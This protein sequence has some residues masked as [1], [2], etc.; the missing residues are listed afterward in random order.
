M[1]NV[2]HTQMVIFFLREGFGLILVVFSFRGLAPCVNRSCICLGPNKRVKVT[3]IR[4]QDKIV[5]KVG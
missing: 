5:S 3:T 1:Y 4:G 2:I